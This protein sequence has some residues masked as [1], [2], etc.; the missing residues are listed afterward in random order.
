MQSDT[1]KGPHGTREANRYGGEDA[2]PAVEGQV[3]ADRIWPRSS[4]WVYSAH[5]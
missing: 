1:P 4:V 3:E 5:R 2:P